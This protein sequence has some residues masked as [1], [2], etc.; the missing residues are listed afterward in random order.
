MAFKFL[1]LKIDV[2][3]AM[4]VNGRYFTRFCQPGMY[5]LLVSQLSLLATADGLYDFHIIF[6]VKYVICKVAS[7]DDLLVD[8]NGKPFPGQVQ[9]FQKLSYTEIVVDLFV[10]AI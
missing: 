8:L 5:Y 1:D 2:L 6:I 7:R 10:A 3:S 9:F 4:S